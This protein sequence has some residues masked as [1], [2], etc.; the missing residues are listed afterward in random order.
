M[1]SPGRVPVALL[2]RL[3]RPATEDWYVHAAARAGAKELMLRRAS[4]QIIFEFMAASE[5]PVDRQYAVTDLL[6][7]ARQEPRAVP[8]KLAHSLSNDSDDTVASKALELMDAIA[9]VDDE[10]RRRYFGAFGM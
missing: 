7:V 3:A 1:V 6:E 10:E 4:A 8:L 5:D 9:H 2:G